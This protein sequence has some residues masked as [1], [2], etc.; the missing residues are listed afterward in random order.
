MFSYFFSLRQISAVI[1]KNHSGSCAAR[2]LQLSLFLLLA[3]L[4]LSGARA[5]RESKAH[6]AMPHSLPRISC[7]L[8]LLPCGLRYGKILQ[9]RRL[10]CG[11]AFFCF[12]A[13]LFFSLQL[14]AL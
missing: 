13:L 2:L 8:L 6:Y 1:T 7:L 12:P 11:D 14:E 3:F 10:F 9:K 4:N 5:L